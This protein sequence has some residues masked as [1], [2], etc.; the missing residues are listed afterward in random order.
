MNVHFADRVPKKI[1]NRQ[2]GWK[3]PLHLQIYAG[4]VYPQV[5]RS[6]S[7]SHDETSVKTLNHFLTGRSTLPVPISEV[8]LDATER[9]WTTWFCR[10]LSA[11]LGDRVAI[12]FLEVARRSPWCRGTPAHVHWSLL[13]CPPDGGGGG[14]GFSP[15][16]FVLPKRQGER[17][18]TPLPRP[19]GSPLPSLYATDSPPRVHDFPTSGDQTTFPFLPA[20]PSGRRRRSETLPL[21]GHCRHGHYHRLLLRLSSTSNGDDPTHPTVARYY[22]SVLLAIYRPLST[23]LPP[24]GVYRCCLAA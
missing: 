5:Q 14:D 18:R 4:I 12:L 17:R 10:H 22:H 19:T 21:T 3:F 24:N 1:R 15:L 13:R 6:S 23:T 7:S 2:T 9:R 11:M 8:R 16:R 20:A